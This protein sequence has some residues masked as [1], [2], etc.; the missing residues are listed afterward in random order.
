MLVYPRFVSTLTQRPDAVQLLPIERRS[1]PEGETRQRLDYIY[2]PDPQQHPVGAAAA[3]HRGA[4]LPGAA[5]DVGVL[6]QRPDGRHA[7]ATDNANDLVETFSLTYNRVRQAS[8][9]REVTEIASAAEAMAA[10]SR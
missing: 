6:L 4:D 1:V 7:N 5:G 3:L 10:D 8:I 9:T 2:E